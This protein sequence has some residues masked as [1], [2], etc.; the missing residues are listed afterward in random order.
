MSVSYDN[1]EMVEPIGVAEGILVLWNSTDVAFTVIRKSN[2][3]MNRV[4]QVCSSS[5]IFICQLFMLARGLK[6]G[7][8]RGRSSV[9][10]LNK[11]QVHG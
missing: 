6:I 11:L 2:Q 4:I 9:F 8:L 5:N 7:N 1:F 10:S 3:M